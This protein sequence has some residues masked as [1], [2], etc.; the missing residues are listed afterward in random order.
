MKTPNQGTPAPQATIYESE[1]IM[2]KTSAPDDAGVSLRV[3]I[4]AIGPE[5]SLEHIKNEGASSRLSAVFPKWKSQL[6]K[7]FTPQKGD[8]N[9]LEEEIGTAIASAINKDTR[10]A[11]IGE[12]LWALTDPQPRWSP[13]PNLEIQ[14]YLA[15][16]G[17]VGTLSLL[18]GLIPTIEL[19]DGSGPIYEE[20][21][22]GY[23]LTDGVMTA[24]AQRI[25]KSTAFR[26]RKIFVA[27][28]A[29]PE[30]R[31]II[32]KNPDLPPEFWVREQNAMNLVN[33]AMRELDAT[34]IPSSLKLQ[35]DALSQL[36]AS[37]GFLS[38]EQGN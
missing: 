24:L 25:T 26:K 2:K 11:P 14:S 17:Q 37:L 20:A 21:K 36:M 10:R 19:L 35:E 5:G 29:T 1:V 13:T 22:D 9:S 3:T 12:N 32:R 34:E 16:G 15:T 27:N 23:L 30:T 18:V 33:S 28:A 31:E 6:A 8:P 7:L 4:E 38:E